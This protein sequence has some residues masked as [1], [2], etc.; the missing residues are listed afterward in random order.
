L[1]LTRHKEISD[2]EVIERYLNTR[3]SSYFGI[4]YKRYS[5]KVYAKCISLL[6][7]E[8]RAE[9]AAQ[10]IFTKIYLN[11]AKF[12]GKSKFSTWIYSITYNYCI[13]VIR[14]NKKNKNVFSDEMERAPDVID[15]VEDQELLL[16][17]VD[18]LKIVLDKIPEGDRAILL[19]K[20]NEDFSIIEIAETLNKSESAVKM[21]IMRAK[22][23]AKAV[24]NDLF[25]EN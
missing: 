13:D 9:D 14:K 7:D 11:L 22:Q 2:L 24:Y 23:K 25:K 1:Q 15:D 16:M 21:K 10:E 3:D 17:R 8:A 19:M 4:L 6:K 20:Y 5:S 12:T 18:R